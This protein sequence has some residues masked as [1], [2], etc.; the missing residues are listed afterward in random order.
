VRPTS[1]LGCQARVGDEDVT[2]EITPE[3]AQAW[4]DEHPGSR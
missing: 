2:F 3:S 1:R 4:L